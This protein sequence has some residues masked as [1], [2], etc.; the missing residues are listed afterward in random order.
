[1]NRLI[2]AKSKD[3]L[4]IVPELKKATAG[5]SR[6]LCHRSRWA[7]DRREAHECNGARI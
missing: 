6:W 3:R 2:E 4:Q 1:M 7:S 5:L